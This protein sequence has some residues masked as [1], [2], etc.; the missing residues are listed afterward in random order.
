[1]K[2]NVMYVM[3]MDTVEESPLYGEPLRIDRIELTPKNTRERMEGLVNKWENKKTTPVIIKNELI[4]KLYEA[5]Y[6][7]EKSEKTELQEL[8]K[9][10]RDIVQQIDMLLF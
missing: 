8:K 5:N 6:K 2:E 9:E 1:M 4:I 7:R 10:L 3:L